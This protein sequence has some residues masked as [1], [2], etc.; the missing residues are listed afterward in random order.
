V[1]WLRRLVT[2]LSPQGFSPGSVHVG[3]FLRQSGIGT[4]FSP[5]YSIFPV[6][7]ILPWL[8]IFVASGGRTVGT[9]IAAVQRHSSTP[10]TRTWTL[11][12]TPKRENPKVTMFQCDV[13]RKI[14]KLTWVT[15][16]WKTFHKQEL[17]N[18]YFSPD[19][20]RK[21][22]LKSKILYHW[23]SVTKII[24]YLFRFWGS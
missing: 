21:I 5:S 9:L 2:D 15:Q 12:L 19:T 3:V 14:K 23:R 13:Q 7:I 24:L 6:I 22:K 16:E 20:A 11:F 1:P 17:H 18:I 10:A 8:S 4:G